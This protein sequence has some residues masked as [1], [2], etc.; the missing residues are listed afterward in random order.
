M[1][2]TWVGE[3]RNAFSLVPSGSD[4]ARMLK[5]IHAQQ[6]RNAPAEKMEVIIAELR[7]MRLGKTV[8][9]LE[10]HGREI[11]TFYGYPDRHWLKLRTN[12][13][14]RFWTLPR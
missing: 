3:V 8:D 10:E 1:K 12:K 14:E 11:L 7:A 4:I 2:C 5:A 13:C 6:S 9:L